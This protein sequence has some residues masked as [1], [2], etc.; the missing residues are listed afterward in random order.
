MHSHAR[1]PAGCVGGKQGHQPAHGRSLASN[2]P[3]YPTYAPLSVLLDICDTTRSVA[4]SSETPSTPPLCMFIISVVPCPML[5]TVPP[6]RPQDTSVPTARGITTHSRVPVQV[7]AWPHPPGPPR[8]GNPRAG[9]GICAPAPSPSGA[10]P[11]RRAYPRRSCGSPRLGDLAGA[12]CLIHLSGQP[13]IPL[14]CR[15][16]EEGQGEGWE[17]L[18]LRTGPKGP[19]SLRCTTCRPS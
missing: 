16:P 7:C 9:C 6:R 18:I 14:P 4:F 5:I 17:C 12:C 8:R 13:H 11:A 19:V 2:R 15:A 10:R 1:R 3:A